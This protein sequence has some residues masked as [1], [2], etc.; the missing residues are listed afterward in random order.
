MFVCVCA[1]SPLASGAAVNCWLA[2]N[3][4]VSPMWFPSAPAKRDETDRGI[5]VQT[6]WPGQR[7]THRPLKSENSGTTPE[8]RNMFVSMLNT[9]YLWRIHI[10]S[11]L[12]STAGRKGRGREGWSLKNATVDYEE[13]KESEKQALWKE[14]NAEIKARNVGNIF[15]HIFYS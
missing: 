7:A 5:C 15:Q 1:L 2:T 3:T 8:L 11:F 6:C 4:L 13:T 9:P 14:R 10:V 12:R